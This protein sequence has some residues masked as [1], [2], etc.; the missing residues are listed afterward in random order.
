MKP[1]QWPSFQEPFY[2]ELHFGKYDFE[3]GFGSPEFILLYVVMLVATVVI[4][5]LKPKQDYIESLETKTKDLKY[6]D[7]KLNYKVVSGSGTAE[8]TNTYYDEGFT[9]KVTL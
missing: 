3:V 4:I 5:F 9:F 7:Y 6:M 1:R 2:N 8:E